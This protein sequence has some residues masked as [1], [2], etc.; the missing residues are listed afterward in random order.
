MSAVYL[1]N[2][3]VLAR[4]KYGHKMFLDS[5]D[6]GIAPHIMLDGIW[7]EWVGNALSSF[8]PQ[9]HFFDIGANVGWF[10]LLAAKSGAAQV[11]AFEPNPSMYELLCD[12]VAV[13]GLTNV[14]C[15]DQALGAQDGHAYLNLIKKYPG[16]NSMLGEET[17]DGR[18]R[19]GIRSLDSLVLDVELSPLAKPGMSR[20]LK[21]DVEGLEPQVVHGA[22]ELIA[23]RE[24]QALFIEYNSYSGS[25]HLDEMFDFLARESFVLGLV[26][27]TGEVR[28]ITRSD[29]ANLPDA[30]MLCFRRFSA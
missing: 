5:R 17:E 19:I 24:T 22:R 3:R 10:T 25:E 6:I 9:A 2:N 8:L 15:Y 1:G 20:V 13:N 4:T 30:A 23:G 26:E 11:F 29:L 14:V 16:S 7:E 21:I 12:N 28:K 18:V 27:Q